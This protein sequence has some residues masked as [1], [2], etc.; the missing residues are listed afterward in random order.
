MFPREFRQRG[1]S[2]A[3]VRLIGQC[4]AAEWSVGDAG[5]GPQEVTMSRSTAGPVPR[6]WLVSPPSP[7]NQGLST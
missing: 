1:P 3:P 7:T 4:L 6:K 2:Q 5:D